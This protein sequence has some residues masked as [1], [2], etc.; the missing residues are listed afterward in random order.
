MPEWL[1]RALC[2]AGWHD[3]EVIDANFGFAPGETTEHVK[4]RRCGQTVTRKGEV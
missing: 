1:G 2:R 4:C 3:F